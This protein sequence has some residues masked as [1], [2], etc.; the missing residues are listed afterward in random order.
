MSFL[1]RHWFDIGWLASWAWLFWVVGWSFSWPVC[2]AIGVTPFIVL[3]I[4]A[5]YVRPG[6]IN[7]LD[8][9]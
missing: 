8:G 6:R 7:E 3:G 4:V 1:K 9:D 2:L 5:L